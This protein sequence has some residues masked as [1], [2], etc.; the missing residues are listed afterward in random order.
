VAVD[1]YRMPMKKLVLGAFAGVVL[2]SC[3]YPLSP[4]RSGGSATPRAAAP[5]APV[6]G[7][8][9]IFPSNNAWNQDVSK[10]RVRKDSATLIH[11]I[12]A[13]GGRSKLHADFGGGGAYGIPFLVVPKTAKRYPIHYT[14][15][16]S[17]SSRGPFPI[18]P[19]APVEGGSNSSGDRHV[20]VVQSGTCHL[21]ELYRAFWR[22]NHW[23]ADSGV[24]WN[25]A[26]NA[27]RKLG[28]TSADAAGLPIFPG[29]ARYSEV[30][31]GAIHH[32]LR[33]TVAQTQRGYIYPATH[34]ASSSNDKAL[35]PMGLR[36]RLKAGYSLAHFHGQALVVLKALKRYGMIVADNGGSWF[37]SGASSPKWNDTDLDQ[38]KTVPGNAFVAV[39][40]GPIRH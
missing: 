31:D 38:L 10:L 6:V 26:S 36:L 20:I 27:R 35:P 12:T 22:G 4:L 37:I 3:A 34:Y 23:D 28:F 29:L 24:N 25:L 15:Y 11:S 18:P 7:G 14:A 1:E 13:T 30:H 19:H 9:Q 33:F 32:A 21:Y 2:A 39:D 5:K 17:E 16:G 8:C 40:T